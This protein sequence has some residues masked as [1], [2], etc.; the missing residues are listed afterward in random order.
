MPDHRQADSGGLSASILQTR[1]DGIFLR[2]YPYSGPDPDSDPVVAWQRPEGGVDIGQRIYQ[3]RDL[4]WEVGR[5]GLG[6][7]SSNTARAL[8]GE[9]SDRRV[10]YGGSSPARQNTACLFGLSRR[11][12]HCWAKELGSE[13]PLGKNCGE[14]QQIGTELAA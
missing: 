5:E 2:T 3:N 8:R 1:T 13:D 12:T 4:V 10:L 7:V 6:V 14:A 11:V 9:H